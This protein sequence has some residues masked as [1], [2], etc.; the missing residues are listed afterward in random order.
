VNDTACRPQ[1]YY[2]SSMQVIRERATKTRILEACHDDRV[3]GCHFGR[4][5]TIDK[6]MACYYWRSIYNDTEE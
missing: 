4:D 6:I 2:L 1:Q 5:R 3:G